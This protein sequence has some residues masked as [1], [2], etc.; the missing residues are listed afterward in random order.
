MRVLLP[1]QQKV[2]VV[3]GL[4]FQGEYE[5]QRGSSQPNWG[6]REEHPHS[7]GEAEILTTGTGLCVPLI[8]QTGRKLQQKEYQSVRLSLENIGWHP[9]TLLRSTRNFSN[10]HFPEVCKGSMDFPTCSDCDKQATS[11]LRKM[12]S[13]FSR[14]PLELGSTV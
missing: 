7:K 2:A 11:R 4:S 1:A 9:F 6:V 8:T 5:R 13:P 3:A 10:Y 14:T 12:S